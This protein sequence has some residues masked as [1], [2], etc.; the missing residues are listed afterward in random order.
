VILALLA[1]VEPQT[2]ALRGAA[3]DA[4]TGFQCQNATAV[5]MDCNNV[6]AACAECLQPVFGNLTSTPTCAEDFN[7]EG[8]FCSG[9]QVCIRVCGK[10]RLKGNKGLIRFVVTDKGLVFFVNSS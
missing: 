2:I 9:G 7:A 6:T 8:Q 5:L 1:N 4:P 3:G 10:P